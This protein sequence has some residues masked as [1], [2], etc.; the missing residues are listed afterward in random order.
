MLM[1]PAPIGLSIVLVE[2]GK[3]AIFAVVLLGIHTIRPI[4]VTIPFVIV[5]V[6]FIMVN[7]RLLLLGLQRGW[8]YCHGGQTSG[9]QQGRSQET[10]EGCFHNPR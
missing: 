10:V 9:A 4:F 2:P 1:T 6:L 5:I 8:R 3:L 7:A